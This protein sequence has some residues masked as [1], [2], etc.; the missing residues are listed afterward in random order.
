VLGL[1]LFYIPE[2]RQLEIFLPAV[3]EEDDDDDPQQELEI[4]SIQDTIYSLRRPPICGI[5]TGY[6]ISLDEA[7][8]WA[9]PGPCDLE[10]LHVVAT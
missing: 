4:Q 10:D 2:L 8:F 1:V 3:F 9:P 6:D 5:R 7:E